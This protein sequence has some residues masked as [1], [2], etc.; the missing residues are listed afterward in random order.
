MVNNLRPDLR[1]EQQFVTETP[2]VLTS[3]L[4]VLYF[5]IHR[6]MV[7]RDEASNPAGSNFIGGQANDPYS[8]PGLVAGAYVERDTAPEAVLR[9]HVFLQNSYG[10]AEVAPSYNWVLD[11]PVF[12]LA[13]SLSATF[14]ISSGTTGGYSAASGRFIDANADFIEDR[15]A[16]GD[17]VLIDGVP[18]LTVTQLDPGPP[19]ASGV[20]SDDELNVTKI[21]K[22]PGTWSGN[23][24]AED[25]N[26]DRTF[27]D[28]TTPSP[29]DFISAG[30]KV[31][32]LLSVA[33]WDVLVTSDGLSYTADTGTGR[34]VTSEFAEFQT[35][36]VQP[37]T[38]GTP[39]TPSTGGQVWLNNGIDWIPTFYVSAIASETQLTA[40]NLL[41]TVPWPPLGG[42]GDDALF[43]IFNYT[44]IDLTGAGV[45]QDLTGSYVTVGLPPVGTFT[46]LAG[47]GID[48]TVL[49]VGPPTNYY[50]VAQ[51][52]DGVRPIF[53]ITGIVAPNV[54][55]IVNVDRTNPPAGAGGPVTW[56]LW[57]D[58]GAGPVAE[59]LGATVSAEGGGGTRTLVLDPASVI[60]FLV[61]P[62]LD[63]GDVV[64]DENWNA[65]FAVVSVDG[66][67]QLTI[68]NIIPGTPPPGWT[69]TTFG[70]AI[71]DED[72]WA[73]LEV[74]SVVDSGTLRVRNILSDPPV[75]QAFSNLTYTIEIAN[76]LYDLNYTIE[77]TLTGT[78]LT[79][80]VLCTY[81]ARRDDWTGPTEITDANREATVGYPVPANPLGL[82][83]YIAL[84]NSN[85][86]IWAAQ[87]PSDTTVDWTNAIE[88]AKSN[89]YYNLCPLTQNE[90]VLAAFRIHV[91]EQS[92]PD[93]KRER[94]MFQSHLNN[95]IEDRTAYQGLGD[96]AAITKTQYVTTI[97]F[98][99]DL[100]LYGV[101]AGD[102]FYGTADVTGTTYVVEGRVLSIVSGVTTTL[103]IVGDNGLPTPPPTIVTASY[104]W[105]ITSKDLTDE[106]YADKIAA[107]PPTIKNRRIRNVYPDSVEIIFTDET[108]PSG[109]SGFYGGGDVTVALP[110]YYGAVQASSL[111]SAK[112]PSQALTRI[113]AIG[114]NRLLNPFGDPYGG[115]EDLNDRI[116]NGGSWVLSQ[117]TAGGECF[118]VR[119]I[120][121][122][123]SEVFKMEDS[124]TVQID[125]FARLLR[126]QITP[127]LGPYNIGGPFFDLVSANVMAI[128]DVVVNVN[129]DARAIVFK[130][131]KEVPDKPDTFAM[132]FDFTPFVSAAKG[133]ITIFI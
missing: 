20:I 78:D 107:Y 31:G 65:L 99:R 42:T 72:N 7:W 56:E 12:S 88:M 62:G 19:P 100:S 46:H 103:T 64:Y 9:P 28:N 35:W 109:N 70:F 93:V 18:S 44:G 94:I 52:P 68:Q 132:T 127:L 54:V 33:G 16:D 60:N 83:C 8:F 86:S 130:E 75:T 3:D 30:V 63:V 61:V 77:K 97:V 118:A 23:L 14:E 17:I 11:P 4:P 92:D 106:E 116:I 123:V 128:I 51:D 125:N 41:T 119:G 112:K 81:T 13:S 104:D 122:D 108:D 115:N 48:F 59:Y 110:G 53:L 82:A 1:I 66:A 71:A 89:R 98:T 22:G 24:T 124:V 67:K 91:E 43:Q 117:A 6:Q 87:V 129:K 76:T 29:F 25:I 5:A 73:I 113:G 50:I 84:L 102:K 55:N 57:F 39:I 96:S 21:D 37:F 90:L 74:K 15:V 95:R 79:G 58:G 47:P 69:S 36:G 131:I 101:V 26:G 80:T 10:I 105:E 49:I 40:Y 114:I 126:Q 2:V 133:E 45:Y 32:D 121:T 120:S 34:T 111:R 85:Y 38:A 27:T